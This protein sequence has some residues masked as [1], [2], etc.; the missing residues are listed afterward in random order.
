MSVGSR[1]NAVV[2]GS[3][4]LL[5][6]LGFGGWTELT[7]G[8][9]A[10]FMS[11]HFPTGTQVG[12][13]V[14]TDP[15]GGAAIVKTTDGGNTWTIQA[16]GVMNGLNSV[17]FIDDNNGYAVGVAATG[18]RTTD[19][20]ATWTPMTIP[21]TDMLNYVRFPGNGQTGYIGV[22]PRNQAG[23]VIK[24]TDGGSI[25][26]D[27][28][29]GGPMSWSI[30]C[31]MATDNI[32]VALGKGGMVYGTTDGFGSASPQGPQTTADLVAAAY[33]PADPNYACLIGNDSLGGVI[34]YT[35]DG[36]AT[37]WD[38]V[39]CWPT[40]TFY[41]VDMP[42][43]TAAYVCGSGG[44]IQRMIS[45][46]PFVDFY[47]TTVPITDDLFGICFPVGQ[48]DTGFVCGANGKIL[49]T[50]DKG[51]PWIPGV[52]E[53]RVPAVKRAGIRV[54]S[55]PSRHGI[56]LHSDADVRVSVYDAAGRTVVSQ[57]ASKGLNFL[58]LPTGAY[59][60]KAG[61]GTARAVVTD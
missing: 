35:D 2:I 45:T 19:G 26:A 61:S 8:I 37:L 39:R 21:G 42:T 41:G 4:L 12:Y 1:R 25:W 48:E 24:T 6:S 34:R 13:A 3:L 46:S 51:I 53:G 31:G 36:G 40:Q 60:V 50:Y 58:P 28:S 38:S 7:S 47:R 52:A 55:N 43:T 57:A 17:Y 10:A 20:G 18:I 33:A 56:A 30:S 5:C 11:I 23:K 14:G 59:F 9:P 54:V 27:V 32:G 44:I 22:Y 49:R 15:A 29:V 16:A